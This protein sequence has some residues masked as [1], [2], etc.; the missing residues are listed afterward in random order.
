V[1][2][3][4][5]ETRAFGVVIDTVCYPSPPRQT[6]FSRK[7]TPASNRLRVGPTPKSRDEAPKKSSAIVRHF[8]RRVRN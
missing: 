3:V 2:A 4:N 6:P 7:R 1:F 5:A 8:E